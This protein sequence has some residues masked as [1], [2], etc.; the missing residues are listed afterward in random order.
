MGRG[1]KNKYFHKLFRAQGNPYL[2]MM[3]LHSPWSPVPAVP[4]A[5]KTQPRVG[6][7]SKLMVFIIMSIQN[8]FLLICRA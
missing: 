7:Q 1:G 6:S 8:H 3:E 5:G 4:G 2:L